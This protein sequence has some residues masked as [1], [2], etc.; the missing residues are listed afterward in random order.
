MT[1]Q[2]DALPETEAIRMLSMFIDTAVGTRVTMHTTRIKEVRAELIR[3]AEENARLRPM[4]TAR[5]QEMLRLVSESGELK[6]RAEKAEARVQELE[7]ENGECRRNER[8]AI[9][10]IAEQRERA[11]TS[12]RR[13]ERSVQDIAEWRPRALTAE[14]ELAAIKKLIAEAQTATV[15]RGLGTDLGLTGGPP[16]MESWFTPEKL[17]GHRVRLLLDDEAKS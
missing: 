6:T 14:A 5:S 10:R 11:E 9:R 8:D 7:R 1:D 16:W 17:I 2:M 13:L 3:L 4:L 12:E 15:C